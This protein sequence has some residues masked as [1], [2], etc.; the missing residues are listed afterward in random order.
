MLGFCRASR[1]GAKE[2]RLLL[3]HI[4]MAAA[5]ALPHHMHGHPRRQRPRVV[6]SGGLAYTVVFCQEGERVPNT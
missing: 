3:P 1:R 4:K 5:N 6:C 2:N